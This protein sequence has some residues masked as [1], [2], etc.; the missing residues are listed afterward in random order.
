M[1][2]AHGLGN[3]RLGRVEQLEGVRRGVIGCN[4][5]NLAAVV[6]ALVGQLGHARTPVGEREHC[7]G[8]KEGGAHG[9]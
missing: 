2:F 4:A 8:H 5:G 7:G 9:G 3:P 1:T 6:C